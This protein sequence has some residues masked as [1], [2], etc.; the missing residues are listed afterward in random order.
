M[1]YSPISLAWH[2]VQTVFLDMDGTLLDLHFDNHFWLEHLPVRL[3]EQRGATPD[4]IRT[5][6]HERYT[7]MEG[8]LDWYCL[9]FWQNHLG[10]DLVALKH[11]IAE[12]IQIRAHVERFLK[13][14][15][16]RGKRVVLLTNAHQKS[17]GMKFGYVALEQ[18]FDRIITSHSLG[19]PK[20]HPDFWQKLSEVEVYD[21]AHSLFIDDNLHVLRSAQAHGVKYLLAIHQPDSQQPPKNTEEFTAVECYTQ[22]MG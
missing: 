8:T 3:A 15:H 5:Y 21:P 11:E 2:E 14:L 13:S 6:L 10:T 19:L 4:E 9:D 22:L 12:R 7:E 17:V 20:E 18:Y 1:N 16:A